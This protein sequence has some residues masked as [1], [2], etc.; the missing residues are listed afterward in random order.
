[1]YYKKFV[2]IQ[3]WIVVFWLGHCNL[4]CGYQH[5]EA[6]YFS[7]EVHFYF[8]NSRSRIEVIFCSVNGGGWFLHNSGNHV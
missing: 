7:M 6:A 5:F 4:I 8:E 3:F 1:M 2:G